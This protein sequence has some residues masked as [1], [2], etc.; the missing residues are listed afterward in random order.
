[1]Q[2][3]VFDLVVLVDRVSDNSD[4]SSYLGSRAGPGL[5]D[6]HRFNVAE[7]CNRMRLSLRPS[8]A[9]WCP[10]KKL[11]LVQPLERNEEA[12]GRTLQGAFIGRATRA[13]GAAAR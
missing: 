2:T 6:E 1:M 10:H 3:V 8:E 12:S 11:P 4:G 5:R 7:R 9:N 13:A